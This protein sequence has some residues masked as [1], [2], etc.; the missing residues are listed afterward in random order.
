MKELVDRNIVVSGTLVAARY[1]LSVPE[2]III[3]IILGKLDQSQAVD[4]TRA[5]R[6]SVDDYVKVRGVSRSLAFRQ[7]KEA[8]DSLFERELNYLETDMETDEVYNVRSRWVTSCYYNVDESTVKLRFVP[9][10]LKHLF[11]LKNN[12]STLRLRE[13]GKLGNNY[14]HRILQLLCLNRFQGH[15]GSYKISLDNLLTLLEV[16]ESY[17]VYGMFKL[18][19]LNPVIKELGESGKNI[20]KISLRE[21]K[22]G[23]KVIAINFIYQFTN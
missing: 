6:V 13:F 23:K 18:R 8:A 11:E 4:T 20:V 9:E 16:P 12:Y 22:E 21:I 14:S 2:H 10:I 7:L 3:L 19:I 5:F 15:K 17:H 1:S